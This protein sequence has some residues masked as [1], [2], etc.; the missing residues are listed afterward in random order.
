MIIGDALFVG[1]SHH[2]RVRST[3]PLSIT[4][5][6]SPYHSLTCFFDVRYLRGMTDL[7]RAYAVLLSCAFP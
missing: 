3:R 2:T 4:V 6:K 7:S 5:D 1:G